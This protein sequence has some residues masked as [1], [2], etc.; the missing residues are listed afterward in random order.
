MP[1]NVKQIGKI[2][3]ECVTDLGRG[4]CGYAEKA[5]MPENVK[6]IG[7]SRCRMRNRPESGRLRLRRK[8]E[9]ARKR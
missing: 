8:G 2:D 3:V 1:E 6:Q 7:A 5:K 4:G 9:N